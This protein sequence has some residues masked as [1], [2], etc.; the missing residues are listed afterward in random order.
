MPI[1]I[2]AYR[3]QAKEYAI[4]TETY[5]LPIISPCHFCKAKRFPHESPNF[6]CSKGEVKLYS[7]N[8]PDQLLEL[9]SGTTPQSTHFLQ[10]IRPYNNAFMFTSFGV[11]LDHKVAIRYKGIYTFRVQGQIYH[12]INS[13]YP[14]GVRPSYLQLYFY[15]TAKEV[16][17]RIRS[18]DELEPIMI[19]KIIDILNKTNPYAIFFRNLQNIPNLHKCEIHLKANPEMKDHTSTAPTVSQVAAI[20]NED[21][22]APEIFERNI[23]VQQHDGYGKIIRYYYGCYD[24]LQYPLLFPY[25]EPGWHQGIKKNTHT[26]R[27][28]YSHGQDRVLPRKSSTAE[29]L[30]TNESEGNS[31]SSG[32]TFKL[33]YFQFLL[34]E[35]ILITIIFVLI[36][37]NS[38]RR[39]WPPTKHGFSQR[40]LCLPV[41][42]ERIN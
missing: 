34:D 5:I 7:I 22:E 4:Q 11:H 1:E 25:G 30:L 15:D 31:F 17:N 24:S 27:T 28:Q 29:E 2:P 14:A 40:I 35:Q 39:I 9:Y 23:I 20:W 6:C 26:N 32:K 41:A 8:I 3:S 13:L 10:Y 21:E 36:S 16:T 18:D 37:L 12:F 38:I 42:N 19:Q 33:F